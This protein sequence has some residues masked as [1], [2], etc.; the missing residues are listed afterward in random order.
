VVAGKW[1][2]VEN[3]NAVDIF[4]PILFDNLAIPF[5]KMNAADILL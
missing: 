1:M 2:L 5:N 4:L 3:N